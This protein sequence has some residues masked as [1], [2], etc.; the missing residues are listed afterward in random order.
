M[1]LR[2]SNNPET[3]FLVCGEGCRIVSA[4]ICENLLVAFPPRRL[5]RRVKKASSDPVS[6]IFEINICPD[7][8]DMIESVRVGCERCHALEADHDV[9][10]C[11]DC[12]V[13]NVSFS[14]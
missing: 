7:D 3:L 13:E 14:E 11:P 1:P 12:H 10:A 6:S 5:I 9:I 4:D 2:R 8:A